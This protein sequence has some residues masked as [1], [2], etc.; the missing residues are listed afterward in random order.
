MLQR[1]TVVLSL[2]VVSVLLVGIIEYT[3]NVYA[4]GA[5]L[6]STMAIDRPNQLEAAA[7]F[8]VEAPAPRFLLVRVQPGPPSAYKRDWDLAACRQRFRAA[9]LGGTG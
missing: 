9:F 1:S 2:V 7:K 6:P 5:G 8:L 4:V 3:P